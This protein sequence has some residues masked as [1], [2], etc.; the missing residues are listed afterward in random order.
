L[1]IVPPKLPKIEERNLDPANWVVVGGYTDD[2]GEMLSALNVLA[3]F[4]H[5]GCFADR[6]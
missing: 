6:P 1:P 3:R 2:V 4:P 5:N